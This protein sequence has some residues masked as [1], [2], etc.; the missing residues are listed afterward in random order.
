MCAAIGGRDHYIALV[1][2]A[3]L[4][5]LQR[6]KKGAV[7]PARSPHAI[8]PRPQ[9]H[10]HPMR[11]LSQTP[12]PPITAATAALKAAAFRKRYASA[13]QEAAPAATLAQVGRSL[14]RFHHAITFG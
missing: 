10:R 5:L 7:A 3:V 8:P 11:T 12:L 1:N 14:T 2:C 9:A 6:R 4:H 13:A